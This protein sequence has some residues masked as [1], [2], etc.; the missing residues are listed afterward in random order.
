MDKYIQVV[1]GVDVG[2]NACEQR[3]NTRFQVLHQCTSTQHIV[4]SS[5]KSQLWVVD[6]ALKRTGCD[7]WQLE[8]QASNVTA[9]VQSDHL[10]HYYMLPVISDTDWSHSTPYCAE[11]QPMSQ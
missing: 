2:E 6:V 5:K 9:S 11:I 10:L 8:C 7:V 4:E 3:S 1:V